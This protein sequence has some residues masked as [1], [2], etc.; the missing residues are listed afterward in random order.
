M[1]IFEKSNHYQAFCLRSSVYFWR[2][3]TPADQGIL[4]HEVYRSHTTTQHSRQDSSGRVISSSQRPLPHNTQQISTTP[5]EFEPTI[6]ADKRPQTY[7]LDRTVTGTGS[8]DITRR[9][10]STFSTTLFF[11][12]QMLLISANIGPLYPIF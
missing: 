7:A 2:N 1:H 9:I 3:S 4:I 8:L 6:S 12:Q 11:L 10:S 5:V